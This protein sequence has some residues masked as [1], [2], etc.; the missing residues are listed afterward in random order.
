[1]RQLTYTAAI[2]EA[3]HIAMQENNKLICY[4]LGTDDPKS[5]FGTTQNLQEQ[6]GIDRVFEQFV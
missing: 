6:F 5:I 2:N 4:G 1:M 3:M